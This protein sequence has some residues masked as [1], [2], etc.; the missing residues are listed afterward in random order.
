MF[1]KDETEGRWNENKVK[2]NLPLFETQIR[3]GNNENKAKKCSGSHD[4]SFHSK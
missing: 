1:V 4:K 2:N 3:V